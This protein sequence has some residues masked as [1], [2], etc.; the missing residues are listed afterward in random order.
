MAGA[1]LKFT[2]SFTKIDMEI[3][4]T[5]RGLTL[6][7]TLALPRGIHARPAAKL[8][9][10]A[11]NYKADISLINENGEVNAKSMLDILSLSAL[12]G[13]EMIILANGSDAREAIS[14]IAEFCLDSKDYYGPA[15]S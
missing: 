8:A 7:L 11:R 13:D 5:Q 2:T 3:T 14:R 10:L 1:V 4:Q 12:H 6:K 9:Q 15:D